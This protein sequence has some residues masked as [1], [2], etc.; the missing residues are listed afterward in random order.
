[1]DSVSADN[2]GVDPVSASVPP[3]RA[4]SASIGDLTSVLSRARLVAAEVVQ[5]LDGGT[6]VLGLAG[7]KVAA[8]SSVELEVGDHLTLGTEGEQ[9][10]VTVLRVIQRSRGGDAP[11]RGLLRSL[12]ATRT[13][14]T[15]TGAAV[16]ELAA[17][18]QSLLP[19]LDAADAD[20]VQRLLARWLPAATSEAQALRQQVE[21]AT[22][23]PEV[24]LLAAEEGSVRGPLAT[25][26]ADEAADE[27]LHTL[28]QG[29]R[30]PATLSAEAKQALRTALASLFV[31]QRTPQAVAAG[32][33]VLLRAAGVTLEP[34]H[35]LV[36]ES[37][38]LQALLQPGPEHRE[39]LLRV[40][41][42]LAREDRRSLLLA[43]SESIHDP[44][45][46]E[47]LQL[48]LEEL[49]YEALQRVVRE[50]EDAAAPLPLRWGTTAADHDAEDPSSS[51]LLVDTQDSTRRVVLDLQYRHLG[52]VRADVRRSEGELWV[53]LACQNAAAQQ[54]LEAHSAEL[55]ALLSSLGRPARLIVAHADELPKPVIPEIVQGAVLDMDA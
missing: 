27:V 33:D 24:L 38:A 30:L 41:A 50:H 10:G 20:E 37:G 53:R 36:A 15:G 18:L 17:H 40:A 39:R 47:H 1:M 54:Q 35:V 7:R 12:L 3:L 55:E 5:R 28:L 51:L 48:A 16:T 2:S 9:A 8:T 46:R 21:A 19:H 6:V 29:G 22:L 49:E 34:L 11:W 44:E 43:A 25:A 23:T 32:L 4:S 26:L 45:V 42:Q 14:A 31:A 52:A 13:G